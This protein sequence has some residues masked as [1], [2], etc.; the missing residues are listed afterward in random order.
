MCQLFL[1]GI[2][3]RG[4][5]APVQLWLIYLL[6]ILLSYVWN[7]MDARTTP[8]DLGLGP[9]LIPAAWTPLV[10]TLNAAFIMVVGTLVAGC[11]DRRLLRSIAS[12]YCV[13]AALFLVYID[14]T[15]KILWGRL[16]ENGVN[17]TVWGLMALT[18]CLGAFARKPGVIALASFGAGIATILLAS[19]REHLLAVFVSL[20]IVVG[21]YYREMDRG[22]LMRLVLG[23]CVALIGIQ[24]LLDPLLDVVHYVASDVLQLNSADRGIDSGFTGRTGIWRDTLELWMRSPV[25]G[26]GYRQHE[27]FLDGAPAHSAYLAVLADTGLLGF[28]VYIVLLISSLSAAWGIQDR[29]TRRF[30]VTMIVAYMISGLFDT[31]TIDAGN[32]YSLLFLMCCSLALA[33][34]SRR[35]VASLYSA[36]ETVASN[37]AGERHGAEAAGLLSEGWATRARSPSPNA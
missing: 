14:L 22:R 16:Y 8:T 2:D 23:S 31:R 9:S 6:I 15:G 37:R 24:L 5:V 25:F 35:R 32:P 34:R 27:Q 13:I 26:V 18:V 28:I 10:Y 19:S 20:L 17:S 3:W 12:F 21:L 1:L 7:L 29:R 33:D 11:P 36:R 30:V 4:L